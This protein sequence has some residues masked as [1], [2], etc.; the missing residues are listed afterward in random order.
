MKTFMSSYMKFKSVVQQE[1]SFKDISYLGLLWASC[2]VERN[3]LCNFKKGQHGEHSCE[4]MRNLEQRFRRRSMSLK[5]IS[6]LEL[7]QPLCSLD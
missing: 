1:I 7:L 3:H 2:S 4:V 6:Y 5:D